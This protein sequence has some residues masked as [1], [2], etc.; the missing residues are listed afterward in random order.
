MNEPEFLQTL[1]ERAREQE[2]II[3]TSSP[4]HIYATVSLWFGKHPWRILI[5]FAFLISLILRLIFGQE[6]FATILG[7][8]GGL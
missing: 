3:K 5:P 4:L 7:I 2:K 1:E 6:F 8:F